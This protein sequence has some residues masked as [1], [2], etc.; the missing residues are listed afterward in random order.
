MRNI[1][2]GKIG[3]GH[4]E[5]PGE[6]GA[7]KGRRGISAVLVH[8]H[9]RTGDD[10]I[11]ARQP[12]KVTIVQNRVVA[13]DVALDACVLQLGTDTAEREGNMDSARGP[14]DT[15]MREGDRTVQPALKGCRTAGTGQAFV[16][17][18]G[19]H[20]GHEPELRR[21]EVRGI[22]HAA[23]HGAQR[24]DRV[25]RQRTVAAVGGTCLE[26]NARDT[27]I[28]L[29]GRGS[30]HCVVVATDRYVKGDAEGRRAY[31]RPTKRDRAS[32]EGQKGNP[33]CV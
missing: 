22:Q 7:W 28:F 30:E 32:A 9:T 18:R 4:R 14:K 13:D 6:N 29:E 24:Q 11:A 12:H 8:V 2:E 33:T 19:S 5:V 31:G 10:A 20:H 27:A 23:A 26:R 16:F 3:G 15:Q 25:L 17:V 1:F 21:G